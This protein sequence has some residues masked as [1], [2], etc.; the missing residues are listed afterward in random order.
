M[1]SLLTVVAST[2]ALAGCATLGNLGSLVQPPQF[3]QAEDRPAEIRL[4]GPSLAQPI[5][6]AAVRVWTNVRN[7]NAFGFTLSTLR[8]TL[9]LDDQRA[10]TGEFPLGL[11]L[12]ALQESVIPL[13]L[14]IDFGDLPGLAGV[15][16][17]AVAGQSISYQL[18]GTI[19]VDAGRLG[20][21]TFGP[22]RLMTGE[23]GA[24]SVAGFTGGP[25]DRLR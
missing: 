19:G 23:I 22:M 14:T 17:R 7:P 6:G 9:L 1:R 24:P 10:A 2:A 11:P 13:D 25:P 3:E 18:D 20:Q 4:A 12:G 8:T 21:P 16:R 5:G 15:I